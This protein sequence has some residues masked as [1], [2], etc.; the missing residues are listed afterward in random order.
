[1]AKLLLTANSSYAFRFLSFGHSRKIQ[2]KLH[3]ATPDELRAVKS[4][5]LAVEYCL[6][7]FGG[8]VM[9]ET[10]ERNRV[11]IYKNC[12]F[13]GLIN[14]LGILQAR[15]LEL[16]KQKTISMSSS[17]VNLEDDLFTVNNSVNF[18]RLFN[19]LRTAK[20][21]YSRISL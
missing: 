21:K 3:C 16:E 13:D 1:M 14:Q 15:E 6:A 18:H 7:N 5:I 17:D 9:P 10:G 19:T 8:I 20:N 12:S 11:M 2:T 4:K